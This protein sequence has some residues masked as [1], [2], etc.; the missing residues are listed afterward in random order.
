M[1]YRVEGQI[2]DLCHECVRAEDPRS[3]NI[4]CFG[5]NESRRR[6]DEINGK[7]SYS[8]GPC[9][10]ALGDGNSKNLATKEGNLVQDE[11]Y[12]SDLAFDVSPSVHRS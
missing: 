6:E 4:G 7:A 1:A 2:E 10:D 8:A 5:E 9:R 11:R 3:A 12:L